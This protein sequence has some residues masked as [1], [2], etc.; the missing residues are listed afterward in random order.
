MSLRVGWF[1]GVRHT[2]QEVGICN[3]PPCLI[4]RLF[5]KLVHLDLGVLDVPNVVDIELEEIYTRNGWILDIS[6][7]RK[8]GTEVGPLP[9]QPLMSR[10]LSSSGSHGFLHS[11][12]IT[13]E[14]SSGGGRE[15]YHEPCNWGCMTDTW[16]RYLVSDK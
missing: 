15:I 5:T 11:I 16:V 8:V 14:S 10:I 12:D 2:I 13:Q 4:N 9:V 1:Y 7:D 6:I 3:R